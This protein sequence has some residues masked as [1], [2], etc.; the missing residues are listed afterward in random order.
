MKKSKKITICIC[1][2]LIVSFTIGGGCLFNF[3]NKKQTMK[4]ITNAV[5]IEW[6]K[7]EKDEL[8]QFLDLFDEK[9][10]FECTSYKKEKKGY[11]TVTTT[12][13]SPDISEAIYEFSEKNKN[14][15]FT[16]E[17][18]D[19]EIYNMI[20]N[21]PMKRSEQ[22]ITVILNDTGTYRVIFSQ[23]FID[24]MFGYIYNNFLTSILSE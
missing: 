10:S 3:Y 22:K 18:F 7:T 2:V 4:E 12:V 17:Q 14:E 11:Y 21:A 6:G 1:L 20:L 23:G 19:N 16:K 13:E 24:G 5:N 15:S 9:A 8:P